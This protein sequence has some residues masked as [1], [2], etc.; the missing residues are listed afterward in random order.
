MHLKPPQFW[1]AEPGTS[2]L[3]KALAPLGAVYHAAVQ[4]R[5]A[6]TEPVSVGVPVICAGNATMGGVGK[7]PFVRAICFM[8]SAVGRTPHVLTRGY[9]GQL[10][11]PVAVNPEHSAAEVG[12]EPLLLARDHPVWISRERVPGAAAAAKAGADVIVM[13]DG[14]QNPSLAKDFSFLLVDAPTLFGNGAVFPAGPLRERPEAARSRSQAV[15]AV[16]PDGCTEVPRTLKRFARGI[17]LIEAWFVLDEAAMP[18]GP[19]LAFCGIG[20]PERFFRALLGAGADLVDAVPFADHHPYAPDDL[21][22]LHERAQRLGATL[23][24][25]EKDLVRLAPS[26]RHGITAIPGRMDVRDEARLLRLLTEVL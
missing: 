7:T 3:S 17:E 22:F 4:R 1:S 5:I 16:L 26:E 24:T 20:R 21:A 8:L 18:E 12:D 13:D 14:L 19:L 10:K 23:V 15:V 2:R 11:G 6:T 25:T 9:G